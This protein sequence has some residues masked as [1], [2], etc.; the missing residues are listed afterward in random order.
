MSSTTNPKTIYYFNPGHEN[1]ILNASPYYTPPANVV[2]MQQD[3]QCLPMWYANPEGY[4]F[5]SNIL[6][7]EYSDFINNNLQEVAKILLASDLNESSNY[8]VHL[9][10]ISPQSI[11]FFE[12]LNH[13]TNAQLQIPSWNEKLRNLSSRET[14][15]QCLS[16]LVKEF[17][18]ISD[19]IIPQFYFDL[20]S[21]EKTVKT[22]QIQLL[23]KAPFSSS[24]RGLLWIPI[25]K[26]TRTEQQILHGIL[27]KQ[28]SVSI[29]R[30]L[31][32]RIDFAMEFGINS[33]TDVVFEGYSLFQTTNKGGY[34]GNY[35]G[36]QYY[37][38]SLLESY[39]NANLLEQIKIR[40]SAYLQSN[41]A[42]SYQGCIG[43]DMMIYDENGKYK[44]HPC[45][46][47]NVRDNM[48]LL[49]LQIS[50]NHLDEGAAG[51]FYIDFSP[52]K[53]GIYERHLQ[54]QKEYPLIISQK[55][56]KQG[57][58]N[59]CPVLPESKYRAYFLLE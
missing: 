31:N 55:K 22:S 45:V 11:H 36:S 24:G 9:W 57:Y 41:F 15:V 14:A 46:E 18:D 39:I 25:S 26:L 4:V 50:K 58:F 10:G 1:A 5:S 52:E 49:A 48:G 20:E 37:I 12:E 28:G 2:A 33:I 53:S 16:L 42:P 7:Q 35:L 54:M 56:F 44:L 19:D 38:Q 29:E 59:L 21:I 40:L 17:D 3:L 32:K 30:V 34:V 13:T 8:A 23:A 27:K 47:I 6:P 51:H 43:I